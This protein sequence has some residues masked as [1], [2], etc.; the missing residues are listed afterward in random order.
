[1]TAKKIIKCRYCEGKINRP[2]TK[3]KEDFTFVE[4]CKTCKRYLCITIHPDGS[5]TMFECHRDYEPGSSS[6]KTIHQ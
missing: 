5:V 4:R 3:P 6:P 1:M 2:I